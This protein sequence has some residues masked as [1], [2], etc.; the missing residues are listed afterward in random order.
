MAASLG[1]FG[2]LLQ[3]HA[4]EGLHGAAFRCESWMVAEGAPGTPETDGIRADARAHRLHMRPDRIEARTMLAVDR[5]GITYSAAQVRG[6]DDVRTSVTYPGPGKPGVSGTVPSALDAI[7]TAL[8]GV[9]I[10]ARP[11]PG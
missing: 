5:A 10:P 1:D 6:Q 4:P 9:G 8:L 2:P 11:D 7:V 3:A